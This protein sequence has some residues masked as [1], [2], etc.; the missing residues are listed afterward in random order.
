MAPQTTCKN[1]LTVQCVWN[2]DRCSNT[3]SMKTRYRKIHRT[4]QKLV[5]CYTGQLVLTQLWCH[6]Q[7]SDENMRIFTYLS[8]SSILI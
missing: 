1:K 3:K 6:H 4:Q 7:A 2:L 8:F 5:Y